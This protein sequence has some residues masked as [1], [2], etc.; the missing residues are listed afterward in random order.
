MGRVKGAKELTLRL[1][2]PR[3]CVRKCVRVC[4]SI[5][6]YVYV[7]VCILSMY[8]RAFTYSPTPGMR[9]EESIS[10]VQMVGNASLLGNFKQLT[11]VSRQAQRDVVKRPD[12]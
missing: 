11:N 9:Q 2:C 7:Y 12:S 10:C 8:I 6:M 1:R 4:M 3:K 5:F